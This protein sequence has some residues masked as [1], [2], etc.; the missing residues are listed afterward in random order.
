MMPVLLNTSWTVLACVACVHCVANMQVFKMLGK[1]S[2]GEE[3]LS[4]GGNSE[5]V[6]IANTT[7]IN[8][9]AHISATSCMS[10]INSTRSGFACN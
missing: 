3:G 8:H 1:D 4:T 6:Y 7:Y 5:P 10:E 2:D 9:C